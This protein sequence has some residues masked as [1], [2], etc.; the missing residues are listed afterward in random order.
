M[1]PQ[2]CIRYRS[3]SRVQQFVDLVDRIQFTSQSYAI[4]V[5]EWLHVRVLL[6]LL[7]P[8]G[9]TISTSCATSGSS[10]AMPKPATDELPPARLP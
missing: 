6:I 1:A 2:V 9:A 10:N 3:M 4:A 8:P 5:P 7:G